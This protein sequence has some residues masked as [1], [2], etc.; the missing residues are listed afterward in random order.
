MTF[1]WRWL[2]G[3]RPEYQSDTGSQKAN[4]DSNMNAGN[5]RALTCGGRSTS[6]AE[7][8]IFCEA[9]TS[10][11]QTKRLVAVAALNKL[12]T[13]NYFSICTLDDVIDIV[14][15]R[16]AGEP[17]KLLSALHCIHYANMEPELREQIPLLVNEC[18]RQKSNAAEAVE[19]SLNGVSI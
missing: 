6:S 16:R 2:R 10:M 14:G 3:L 4:G 19:A 5:L 13:S 7:S 17:Y 12:F 1:L 18:L 8:K 9:I 15:A 11:N